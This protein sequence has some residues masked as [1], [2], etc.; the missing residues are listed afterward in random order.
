MPFHKLVGVA[1]DDFLHFEELFFSKAILALEEKKKRLVLLLMIL[2]ESFLFKRLQ[3]LRN[4]LWLVYQLLSPKG[5]LALRAWHLP[6]HH[7]A[8]F[9]QAS[10]V[11]QTPCLALVLSHGAFGED[12]LVPHFLQQAE[13]KISPISGELL[14]DS[15]TSGA[16]S[17]PS[18]C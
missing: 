15:F 9:Y 1:S 11:C 7:P 5:G 4:Q 17:L 10:S 3:I 16:N 18:L 8:C 6:S 13:A 14:P 2:G 12:P